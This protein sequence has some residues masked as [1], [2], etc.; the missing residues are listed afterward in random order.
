ML[1]TNTMMTSLGFFSAT[2]MWLDPPTLI[3][4]IVFY[5]DRM[6]TKWRGSGRQGTTWYRGINALLYPL[7]DYSKKRSNRQDAFD[8]LCPTFQPFALRAAPGES[9]SSACVFIRCI[10]CGSC[11]GLRGR[12]KF[13][14]R[15]RAGSID[16]R[17]LMI[18]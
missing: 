18:Y 3:D 1:L 14:F 7:S 4:C 2:L 12:K 8:G 11:R 6:L 16:N 9:R 15:S 5:P 10:D 13:L 17:K